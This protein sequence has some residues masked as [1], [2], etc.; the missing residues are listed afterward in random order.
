MRKLQKPPVAEAKTSKKEPLAEGLQVAIPSDSRGR[1]M[2]RK[3][4]DEQIVELAKA[5][6]KEGNIKGRQELSKANKRLYR[7]LIKRGLSGEID[8]ENKVRSWSEKSDEEVVELARR[9]IEIEKIEERSGLERADSGLYKVLLT[10]GLLG[11][12]G[13]KKKVRSWKDMSDEQIIEYAKKVMEEKKIT[14]RGELQRTDHGLYEVLRKRK[15]LDEVGFE[16]NPMTRSWKDMSDEEVVV[17]AKRVIEGKKITGR[18]TLDTVD[19]TLYSVLRKRKLLGQVGFEEKLRS[20]QDMSD[21]EV[22]ELARKT[23]GSKGICKRDELKGVDCGVYEILRIR[24]LLDEVGFE[25]KRRSWKNMSDEEL[26][27]VAKIILKEK[28]ICGRKE[29]KSADSGLHE[30]LRARGLLDE[31]GFR[32]K[33]SPWKDL[34]DEEI[35]KLARELMRENG[36]RLKGELIKADRKLYRV[37]RKRGLLD[38]INFV[39]RRRYWKNMT[40]EQIVE[41]ARKVV[42]KN[43]IGGRKELSVFDR[44]LY[45]VLRTRKLLDQIEFPQ[46]RK[47]SKAWKD[48]SDDELLD[49]AKKLMEEKEL[50]GKSEL[51]RANHMLYENLRVR[52]L[53]DRIDFEI[54]H[55]SWKDMSNEEIVKIARKEIKNLGPPLRKNLQRRD[56]GLYAILCRRKLIDLAFSDTDKARANLARDAVID[57]LEAFTVANDNASSEDDVA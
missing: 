49:L 14:R 34:S 6:M 48:M 19:Q 9:I 51:D 4:K 2:W 39:G 5:T 1:I 42:E 56:P 45:S 20:W 43:N 3:I 38:E 47:K 57:A 26:V 52:G 46:I 28:E 54:N 33:Q 11:D 25:Q 10:R 53:L 15:L 23:M 22:V 41:Y 55:R 40:D 13:F 36:I 30:I 35:V 50:K 37:L 24:G 44:G 7:V 31:V 32:T 17:L 27:E 12:V 8:F 29:L 16:E 18:K 21:E